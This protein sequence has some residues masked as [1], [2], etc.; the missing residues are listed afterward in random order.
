MDPKKIAV[1]LTPILP[2]GENGGA[3]IFVLTLI[4][5]LAKISPNTHFVLLTQSVSHEEL[6]FL[7]AGNVERKVVLGLKEKSSIFSKVRV[8][9]VSCLSLMPNRIATRLAKFLNFFYKYS[10]KAGNRG[11]LRELNVDVLFCPFTAPTYHEPGIPVV[12]TLYDLQYKTYP[13]FFSNADVVHRDQTFKKAAEVASILV[14]I[15]D[16]TRSIC[17]EHENIPESDIK[18]IYLKMAQRVSANNEVNYLSD[19]GLKHQEYLIYPANFWKHKNHEMLLTAFGMAVSQG[20]KSEIKLVLTGAVS[21]RSEWLK[22]VIEM[23]GLSKRVVITGFVSNEQL[24]QLI[25][26]C[27][28]MVFPSLYEGFGL[29]VIEAMAAGVPVA[30]SNVTSLPEIA[31]D[32]AF[33]F[34]PK[35]PAQIAHAINELV[36]NKDL[37]AELTRK[38]H[39]RSDFFSNTDDMVQQYWQVLVE[40]FNKDLNKSFVAGV[41][42]DK[43]L[44]SALDINIASDSIIEHVEIM[45]STPE[46]LEKKP[47]LNQVMMRQGN[48][49]KSTAYT[50]EDGIIQIPV[51]TDQSELTLKFSGC[52]IPNQSG[53]G[54]DDRELS[55]QLEH[56]NL[57]SSSNE[58]NQ[59]YPS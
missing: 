17:M 2:G 21:D 41:Y 25:K 6:S 5:R 23:Q 13:Q 24:A 46:W 19:F 30:C 56:I 37:C 31:G 11:L 59:I 10:K 57:V 29:P 4:E 15:S 27:K 39:A 12:S 43:W 26:H 55:V 34:N 14:P 1:D 16:Y 18:T 47:T 53:L 36:E 33:L 28:G 49:F 51:R 20:L 52:F 3:K 48:K 32:A 54:G 50:I 38:G 42:P 35:K 7:D 58:K 9:L 22:S 44:G 45:L 40:A 8:K